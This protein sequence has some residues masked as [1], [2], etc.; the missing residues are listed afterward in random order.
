MS[1]DDSATFRRHENLYR[2]ALPH[3]ERHALS[4]P[5]LAAWIEARLA[6]LQLFPAALAEEKYVP[7]ITVFTSTCAPRVASERGLQHAAE[8]LFAFFVLNDATRDEESPEVDV[9]HDF[10]ERWLEGL[11]QE[12]GGRAARFQEAF[13]LYRASLVHERTLELRPPITWSE[14]TDRALGRHQWVATAPYLELWE[15]CEGVVVPE[16]ERAACDELKATAVDLTY[17]A[18]DLGSFGRDGASKNFVSLIADETGCNREEALRATVEFY[19]AQAHSFSEQAAALGAARD[20]VDLVA[21]VTDGNLR[22]TTFLATSDRE[23]RYAPEVRELLEELAH[24]ALLAPGSAG[25][26]LDRRGSE[27]AALDFAKDGPPSSWK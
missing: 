9:R 12:Y 22:A 17:V 3:L 15:L 24:R 25:G 10:I 7:Q 5:R 2:A 13:A 16:E 6:E 4:V 8:F 1:D 19:V 21:C 20:Y 23:G 14:Y 26:A 11:N 18:N 27:H